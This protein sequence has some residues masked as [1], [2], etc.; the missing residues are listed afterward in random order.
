[1][2]NVCLMAFF[3]SIKRKYVRSTLWL[4]YSYINSYMIDKYGANL[5]IFVQLTK[6]IKTKISHYVAKKYKTFTAEQL[7][8]VISHCM[9][10]E[11]N[12]PKLML[13]GICIAV[14]YYRLLQMNKAFLIKVQDITIVG[15]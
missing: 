11:E 12:D 14:M 13:Y 10:T 9:H 1:M 6:Y 15:E 4:V 8:D 3:Q 7:H 2:E 5:K